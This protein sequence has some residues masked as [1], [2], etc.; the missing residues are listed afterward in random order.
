MLSEIWVC[1]L[2]GAPHWRE[3]MWWGTRPL[4]PLSWR[5]PTPIPWRSTDI[6]AL[7]ERMLWFVEH[8]EAIGPM[9]VQSRRLAEE[10]FDVRQINRRLM[11]L[12]GVQ[13]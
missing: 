5:M 13:G 3:L 2:T 10:R 7:A 4:A 9:G 1:K 6:E 8:P 11:A 12:L